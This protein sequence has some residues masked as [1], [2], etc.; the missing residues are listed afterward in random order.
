M[1]NIKKVYEDLSME[2]AGVQVTA[3]FPSQD[4]AATSDKL[5]G[6]KKRKK[7]IMNNK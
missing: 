7:S 5:K 2:Y 1:V 6:G 3:L 4:K